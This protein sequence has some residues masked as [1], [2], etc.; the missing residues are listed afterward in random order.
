MI[1]EP[2]KHS[3]RNPGHLAQWLLPWAAQLVPIPLRAD[4]QQE[5][6]GELWHLDHEHGNRMPHSARA[7]SL[8]YGLLADA[9]WLRSNY[10]IQ[11]S[12]GSAGSCLATLAF[13]CLLSIVVSW[14]YSGSAHAFS[15]LIAAHFIG[16]YIFVAIPAIFTAIATNPLRPLRCDRNQPRSEKLL[17]TR[18]RW[19]LFLTAK[20]LLTLILVFFGAIAA[21]APLRIFIGRSADWFELVL[22]AFAVTAGLRWALLNQER[23]CQRCLRILNQ[24]TRI[25]PPSRNFLD[26]N[27]TE[28]ACADGHGLLHVP[29]MQGS[30][31]WYDRWVE[32]DSTL[33]TIW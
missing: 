15:G 16:G 3:P 30:W 23:R 31:C 2:E 22:W 4:W 28:L 12:R 1:L 18:A 27:G 33:Q 20:I 14:V 13:C 10:V 25:G 24:P 6:R 19:N 26:W 7:L 21:A 8:A 17:S 5:W 9:F 29:E 32:L 11:I